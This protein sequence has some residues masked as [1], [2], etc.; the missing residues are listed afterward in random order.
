VGTE[1]RSVVEGFD[2]FLG[3]IVLGICSEGAAFSEGAAASTGI[4]E[5]EG[6]S[7]AGVEVGCET[8]G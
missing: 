3:A 2:F 4:R 1:L 5:A 8:G 7:F 6:G